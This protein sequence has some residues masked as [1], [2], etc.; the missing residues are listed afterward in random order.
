[1][2]RLEINDEEDYIGNIWGWKMSFISLAFIVLVLLLM[3]GR[4]R[5]LKSTGEY[6]PNKID[7]TQI[8]IID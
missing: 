3:F 4:Y 5:Y 1:M 7:T 6:D 2:S 8:E